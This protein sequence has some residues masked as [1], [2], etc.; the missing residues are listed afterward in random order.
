MRFS[1]TLPFP[2][3][4]NHY[5]NHRVIGKT[6]STYLT[7]AG[8]CFREAVAKA[9]VLCNGQFNL[10]DPVWV[11]V[12]LHAPDARRRDL[13]NYGGK[14]LLDALTCAGVWKDDSQVKVLHL[15]WGKPV[16]NGSCEV[17]IKDLKGYS[18]DASC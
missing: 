14:A 1:I 8:R 6:V 4:V 17:T 7:N 16:P 15:A 12:T 10:A 5:W 13:D 3:S 2:P 9:I 11:D 18:D